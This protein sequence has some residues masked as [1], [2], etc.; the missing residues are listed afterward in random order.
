M[1]LRKLGDEEG[2]VEKEIFEVNKKF[3]ERINVIEKNNCLLKKIE[4]K[5]YRENITISVDIVD[6]NAIILTTGKNTS[7]P[8]LK[9]NL[10]IILSIGVSLDLNTF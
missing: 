7:L 2:K 3:V 1:L 5:S 6:K 8:N 4:E 10:P 9:K